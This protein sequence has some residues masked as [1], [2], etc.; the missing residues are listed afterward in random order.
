MS[1]APVSPIDLVIDAAA[2]LIPA[3]LRALGVAGPVAVVVTPLTAA[4]AEKLKVMVREKLGAEELPP[5]LVPEG[6]SLERAL[7]EE[8]AADAARVVAM[9]AP[10]DRPPPSADALTS[11]G[12]HLDDLADEVRRG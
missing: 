6:A 3:G 7:A 1:T 11:D 9:R 10:T 8:L 5:L 2:S 12:R 4:L